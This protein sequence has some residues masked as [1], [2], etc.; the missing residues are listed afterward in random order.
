MGDLSV[1]GAQLWN[2]LLV[3]TGRI[4]PEALTA[5]LQVQRDFLTMKTMLEKGIAIPVIVKWY[6]NKSLT[7]PAAQA[8]AAAATAAA[9]GDWVRRGPSTTP[10]KTGGWWENTVTGYWEERALGGAFKGWAMVG[11]APGG[12]ITPYTEWVY[13]SGT[14]YNQAQMAGRFAPPM[15]AGGA[16]PPAKLGEQKTDI[17]VQVY[18]NVADNI[19]LEAMAY[20]VAGVI[21]RRV[22]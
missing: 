4:S 15:A 16:I 17:T 20:R 6:E 2:A 9:A 7:G 5:F 11:D 13:G 19:D 12:G 18:A 14:V 10:G 21:S 1:Q 22:S 3:S 8:A